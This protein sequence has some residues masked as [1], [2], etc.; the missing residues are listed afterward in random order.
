MGAINRL[1]SADDRAG[2]A[3]EIVRSDGICA[4]SGQESHYLVAILFSNS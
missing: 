3:F 2:L 4:K 1:E